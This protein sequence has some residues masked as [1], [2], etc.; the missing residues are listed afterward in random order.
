[1]GELSLGGHRS[2]NPAKHIMQISDFL[3]NCNV[4]NADRETA[5]TYALIK[6]DLLNK[7]KPIPEND[8]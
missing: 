3:K 7:G 4:L 8:I 6:A 1:L 2:S 5:N